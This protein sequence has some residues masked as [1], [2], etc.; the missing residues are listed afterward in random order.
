[1]PTPKSPLAL[2][3]IAR[4]N[5]QQTIFHDETDLT[6]FLTRLKQEVLPQR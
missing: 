2:H 4:G 6:D 1:M 5:D 3:L